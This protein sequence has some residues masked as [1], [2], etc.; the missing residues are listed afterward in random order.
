M[1]TT[2]LSKVIVNKYYKI[3]LILEARICVICAL[4]V[5]ILLQIM[6]STAYTTEET[7]TKYLNANTTDLLLT[8]NESKILHSGYKRTNDHNY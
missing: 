7:T 6:R 5:I 8:T 2:D 3:M 4:F 1:Q